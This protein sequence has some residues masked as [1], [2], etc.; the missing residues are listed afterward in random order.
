MDGSPA[1]EFLA[2]PAAPDVI[3][4]C[5]LL[6]G[7]RPRVCD[8]K[9]SRAALESLADRADAAEERRRAV[10]VPE[11]AEAWPWVPPWS[12]PALRPEGLPQEE[13]EL[14]FWSSRL[15]ESRPWKVKRPLIYEEL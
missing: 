8:L 15:M 5:P 6:E 13:G 2:T 1:I 4:L 14:T 7:T 9:S 12:W 11:E 3:D 10:L